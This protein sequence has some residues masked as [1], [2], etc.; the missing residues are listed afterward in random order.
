M[1]VILINT[2]D[3]FNTFALSPALEDQLVL[4]DVETS[5]ATTHLELAQ[6]IGNSAIIAR[7]L[8]TLP[9]TAGH[10]CIIIVSQPK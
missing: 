1:L 3:S 2:K 9:R 7:S 5:E 10:A 8:T 4:L 6:H